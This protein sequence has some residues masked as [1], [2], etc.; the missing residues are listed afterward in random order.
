M[1][2][3]FSRC[4]VEEFVGELYREELEEVGDEERRRSSGESLNET[5]SSVDLSKKVTRIV[6]VWGEG[7]VIMC[8]V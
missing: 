6:N 3:V 5:S 2:A 4:M 7:E 8:C 1:F